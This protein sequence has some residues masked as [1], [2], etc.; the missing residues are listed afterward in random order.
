MTVAR[1]L[2][3][4]RI[5]VT[6]FGQQINNCVAGFPANRHRNPNCDWTTARK[7]APLRHG[8]STSRPTSVHQSWK[9]C[10][11]VPHPL[12]PSLQRQFDGFNGGRLTRFLPAT[13]CA[14]PRSQRQRPHTTPPARPCGTETARCG[15]AIH[16]WRAQPT[17]AAAVPFYQ[18]AIKLAATAGL[19]RN[20]LSR[21]RS[22][23][24]TRILS[25]W[26]LTLA[27]GPLYQVPRVLYECGWFI[28]N[29]SEYGHLATSSLPDPHALALHHAPRHSPHM[30][31]GWGGWS[32][33]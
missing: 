33:A 29:D 10:N 18:L 24:L 5:A 7:L 4:E 17:N 25:S 31:P 3:T 30:R 1:N 2:P 28:G 16:P 26:G 14:S 12:R 11:R 15:V 8:H 32:G 27:D 23:A 13:N 19:T 22:R 21:R 6:V 20:S 9:G